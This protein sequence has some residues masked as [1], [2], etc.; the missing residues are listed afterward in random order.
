MPKRRVIILGFIAIAV[1]MSGLIVYLT[2]AQQQVR[3]LPFHTVSW[4]GSSSHTAKDYIIVNNETDWS[5]AWSGAFGSMPLPHISFVDTTVIAV[6]TGTEPTI[7][8]ATNVTMVIQR[9]AEVQVQVLL[10]TPGSCLAGE[11]ITAPY[12]IISIPKITQPVQFT[13]QTSAR[14]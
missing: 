14:C 6:F 13:T 12:H 8:Y 4:G 1:S 2:Y 3:V 9:P 5:R 7:G 10:T 11:M